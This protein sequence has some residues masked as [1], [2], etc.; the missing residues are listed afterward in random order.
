MSATTSN[1]KGGAKR[2]RKESK[3]AVTRSGICMPC[4][5]Q[6]PLQCCTFR[7]NIRHM[8]AAVINDHIIA[9]A[10]LCSYT[11]VFALL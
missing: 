5:S 4:S 11:V 3:P 7:K 8:F 2:P 10:E 9:R 6:Q 1:S